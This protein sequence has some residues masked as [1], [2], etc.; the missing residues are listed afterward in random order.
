MY[1]LKD[2]SIT[3]KNTNDSKNLHL[4]LNWVHFAF[5]KNDILSI[6]YWLQGPFFGF[7]KY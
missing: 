4:F 2:L 5:K 3:F 6:A 1:W 7:Q